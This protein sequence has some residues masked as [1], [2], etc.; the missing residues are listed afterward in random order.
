MMTESP[1]VPVMIHGFMRETSIPVLAGN[2][3]PVANQPTLFTDL[4]RTKSPI[5]LLSDAMIIIMTMTGTATG[6]VRDLFYRRYRSPGTI[7][8]DLLTTSFPDT[9]PSPARG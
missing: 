5:T 9:S 6:C 1:R 4:E 2:M 8:P 3:T 7:F